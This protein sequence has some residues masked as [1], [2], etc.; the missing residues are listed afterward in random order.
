MI[1]YT[2]EIQYFDFKFIKIN[3]YF[4]YKYMLFILYCQ[5][6]LDKNWIT[7]LQFQNLSQSISVP[8]W[9]NFF[10][11]FILPQRCTFLF[12]SSEKKRQT[13]MS[14]VTAFFFIKFSYHCDFCRGL[15]LLGFTESKWL[16]KYFL[17]YCT[18]NWYD[19]VSIFWL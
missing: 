5:V 17:R 14:I 1:S 10:Q 4:K 13:Q 8:N 18:R 9:K 2:N 3:S 19:T 6:H 12:I 7:V 11:T 15:S 16:S